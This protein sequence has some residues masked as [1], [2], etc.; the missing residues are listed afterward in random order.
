MK[1]INLNEILSKYSPKLNQQSFLNKNFT[2][3]FLN[4]ILRINKIN[5]FLEEHSDSK[6]EF[7]IDALFEHLNFSYSISE[8]DIQ[9][10]PVEGK[11]VIV[12]NHPLGALDALALIKLVKKVR[13][14]V[15]ILANEVLQAIDNINDFLLPY[16]IFSDKS[17]KENIEKIL[18]YLEND[19]A[20]IIFPAGKV[21]RAYLKNFF[22]IKDDNWKKGAIYLA[23]KTNS[24]I[25]PIYIKARN[26]ALFYF[27]S[28]IHDNLSTLLLPRE[29]FKQANK[30][31]NL[32]I[33][34]IIPSKALNSNLKDN[35]FSKVLRKHLY[36]IGKGKKGI[37]QT[38]KNIIHPIDRKLIKND[39]YSS[40]LLGETY[41]GKKIFVIEGDK[42]ENIL[43]EIARL[44]EVTFRKVGEGTGKRLDQ[45]KY[46]RYYSHIVLWD[47]A[48]LEIVGSYRIAKCDEVLNSIGISGL[49]CSSLYKFEN[50]FVEEILPCSI[51]LGRSFVQQKYWNTS[52]LDNLWQGIGAFLASNPKYK[53]L[54]GAVS[55]SA[56][57]PE[58]AKDMIVYYYEK[59]F[60]SKEFD[61]QPYDPFLISNKTKNAL[62]EIFNGD[63]YKEDYKILKK[64]LKMYNCSPP[65]LYKQYSELVDYGGAKI[66]AFSIDK[67]F[68]NCIDGFLLV[69]LS[70]LKSEKK[71]RYILKNKQINVA[72]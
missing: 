45:D 5:S 51:E 8:K 46:D 4:K 59:W 16:N 68:N 66:F 25:L 18:E 41:D 29:L 30:T 36:R 14:D 24:P 13:P 37:F 26:S 10:I 34:D 67:A 49:Y 27:V 43:T 11:V 12:A 56:S 17:Q 65:V 38:E 48:N 52:A 23:K 22:T 33:G 19:Y 63:N 35:H 32:V 57:Y 20:I 58:E 62:E 6:N 39:L 9:K 1:K 54:M 61:I 7:F 42:Y 50:K 70:K 44:R 28:F 2:L 55:I 64:Y 72:N 40:T 69:D 53:Y 3:P 71:D 21:S 60:S 31:I 15:K 47:D